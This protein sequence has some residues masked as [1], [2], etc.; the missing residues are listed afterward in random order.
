MCI[1]WQSKMKSNLWTPNSKINQSMQFKLGNNHKKPVG[2]Q[3]DISCTTPISVHFLESQN[4]RKSHN[5]NNASGSSMSNE[6]SMFRI[7]LQETTS[8]AQQVL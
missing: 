6:A 3:H 7:A 8:I 5:F 4:T 2:K 1:I